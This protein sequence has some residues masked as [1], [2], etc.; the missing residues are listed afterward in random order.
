MTTSADLASFLKRPRPS[1]V[2]EVEG[3]AALV[4]VVRPEVEA[5]VEVG[6][7]AVEGADAAAAGAFAGLD[8]DDVGAHVGEKLAGQLALLVAN[9][10]D[11]EAGEGLRGLAAHDA[12]FR[13]IPLGQK[14]FSPSRAS[15][16]PGS[17]P[18]RS[19]KT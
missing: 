9:L 2:A 7:V 6:H 3:E 13:C 14:T 15:R 11:A 18:R 17:M 5:A 8:E 16:S 19:S 12:A 10:Q 1:G 4:G